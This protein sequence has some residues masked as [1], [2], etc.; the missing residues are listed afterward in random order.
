MNAEQAE[1][2][3]MEELQNDPAAAAFLNQAFE[4]F[5]RNQEPPPAVIIVSFFIR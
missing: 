5:R 4:A 3:S 1:P 2:P